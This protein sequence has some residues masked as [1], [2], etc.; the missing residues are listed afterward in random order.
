MKIA[1][2]AAKSG[3]SADTIRYYERIGLLANVG[4]SS[5]G[6]RAFTGHDLRWLRM[7]ERLRSTGMPLA[8]VKRYAQLAREGQHSMEERRILLEE[9]RKRL[10][11]QQVQL[12]DCRT[13]IDEKIE[14]YLRLESSAF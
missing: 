12:D 7:F 2:A 9:H 10:D 1:E 3:L 8:Q 4:R 14:N 13:L 6:H 11:V 5:D